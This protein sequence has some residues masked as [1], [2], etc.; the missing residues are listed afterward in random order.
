[1]EVW[2]IRVMEQIR[3]HLWIVGT[4]FIISVIIMLIII[5][6]RVMLVVRI[7]CMISI[8]IATMMYCYAYYDVL[9]CIQY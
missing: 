2:R 8:C 5:T 4:Q 6:S 3:Q 7:M 1:M 9:L